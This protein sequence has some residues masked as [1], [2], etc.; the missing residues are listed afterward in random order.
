MKRI[1]VAPLNWGL[2]HATR[3]IPIINFLLE[4]KYTPIIASDGAS[5]MLL[6]MEFPSLEFIALPSYNIQYAKNLKWSLLLQVPKI[7]K[8]VK[9]EKHV[10]ATY[11]QNNNVIGIISDSRFGVRNVEIPSA[12]TSE[13]PWPR[14]NHTAAQRPQRPTAESRCGRRISSRTTSRV[15]SRPA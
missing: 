15:R 1:I 4:N 14:W 6:R 11:I 7:L 13:S 10:I 3:C 2:G 5:L 8:A 9:K 12:S